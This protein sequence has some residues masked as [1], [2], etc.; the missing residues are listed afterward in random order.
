MQEKQLR[1]QLACA[2]QLVE[3]LKN[4]MYIW[5]IIFKLCVCHECMIYHI[6]FVYRFRLG[7]GVVSISGG[8]SAYRR[9]L[10]LQFPRTG[11]VAM[12]F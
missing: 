2:N 8:V 4:N 6:V 12:D 9:L 3:C 11:L 5:N 7:R 1:N 10:R